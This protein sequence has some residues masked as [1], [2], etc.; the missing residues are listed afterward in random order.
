VPVAPSCTEE[1]PSIVIRIATGPWFRRGAHTPNVP[2]SRRYHL[3]LDSRIPPTP[4]RLRHLTPSHAT[5]MD[6][7]GDDVRVIRVWSVSPHAWVHGSY[8]GQCESGDVE[9]CARDCTIAWERK[10]AER[11]HEGT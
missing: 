9:R 7:G 4:S 8:T 5:S 1:P 6:R 3:Y 10:R 11:V 2:L